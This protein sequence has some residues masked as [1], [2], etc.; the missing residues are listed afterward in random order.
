MRNDI[1]HLGK[2][3]DADIYNCSDKAFDVIGLVKAFGGEGKRCITVA[4]FSQYFTACSR[5]NKGIKL[6]E[7]PAI[8][9]DKYQCREISLLNL[10][11]K[12]QNGIPEAIEQ[13]NAIKE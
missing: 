1:F 4:E 8:T 3:S 2:N 7:V 6:I 5:E 9:E 13:W 12:A 10:Y 11:I